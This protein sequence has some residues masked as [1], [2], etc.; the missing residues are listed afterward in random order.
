MKPKEVYQV[1]QLPSSVIEVARKYAPKP[2]TYSLA[3][4]GGSY[5]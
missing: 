2:T 3:G 4:N 5:E 1:P